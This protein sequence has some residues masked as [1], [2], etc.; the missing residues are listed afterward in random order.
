M[1][2]VGFWSDFAFQS[3]RVVKPSGAAEVKLL[4]KVAAQIFVNF[5][6]H[7]DDSYVSTGLKPPTSLFKQLTFLFI[8]YN[9]YFGLK[10][11]IL[12][13]LDFQRIVSSCDHRFTS[14]LG[15]TGA[16]FHCYG[17]TG[18]RYRSFDA[19]I[20]KPYESRS[21]QKLGACNA[22]T[23]Q[24]APF[25]QSLQTCKNRGF[26][27]IVLVKDVQMT[28]GLSMLGASMVWAGPVFRHDKMLSNLWYCWWLKSCTTWD[29]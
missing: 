15:D 17:L 9:P 26:S 24:L 21:E 7:F 16:F 19:W 27:F 3:L 22:R 28:D 18:N 10:T 20:H 11:F 14:I 12:L 23:S 6:S 8:G 13:V 25:R 29:V 5:S 1:Q 2:G 4:P